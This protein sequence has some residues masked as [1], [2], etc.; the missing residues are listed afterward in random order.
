MNPV[1][2]L[3]KGE[4]GERSLREALEHLD[5]MEAIVPKVSTVMIKPNFTGAL[6]PETGAA[7][8]PRIAK[9]LAKLALEA[10]ASKVII[11]EG[12]GSGHVS[13]KD[14]RGLGEISEMKG[15]EVVD[16]NDEQTEVVDI[17]EPLAVE[18]FEIP[19]VVLECDFLINLAKLKVHPQ[20]MF[21]LAM[22]NLLG[23]LP[24]RSFTD[25]EEAKRRG[26][27]TPIIP[28]GGKKIFHDLARDRG[29]DAMQDA[30][31]DLNTVIPSHLTVID[32][33]YGMEGKGAPVQG[34][35]V[36]MDLLIA[37]TDI[38]AVEAVGAAAMGFDP[39]SIPYLEHAVEKG[40]GFGYRIEEIDI[41]G[42]SLADVCHEFE[43]ASAAFLWNEES[44]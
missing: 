4:D 12:I 44:R 35:A 32:G 6:P 9:E 43:P 30:I 34:R 7:S 17:S 25:P 40:L 21:S 5:G 38:V 18:R 11:A 3:I 2:S 16:L 37:G 8:D 1:V 23:A 41:R 15:V 14:V 36:K 42:A 31:V 39:A 20:A 22:K 24:G 13:L 19:R 28:G 27:L 10:G 26:Y 29:P 33:L